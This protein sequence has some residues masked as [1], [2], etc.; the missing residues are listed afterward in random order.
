M[1]S[2]SETGW[3]KGLLIALFTFT[4]ILLPRHGLAMTAMDDRALASVTGQDGSLFLA[5]HISPNE[6]EGA[7]ADGTANFDF[8][9]MGLDAKLNLNLNISLMLI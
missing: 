7:P 9:R 4:A 1:C 5:D 2:V 6:L 8:Y 3:R